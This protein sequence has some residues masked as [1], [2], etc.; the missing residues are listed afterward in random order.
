M[1]KTICLILAC[2]LLSGCGQFPP[3]RYVNS[4]ETIA[5]ETTAPVET[6]VPKE[7]SSGAAVPEP[8]ESQPTREDTL[9][10]MVDSMTLEQQVAQMFLVRCPVSDAAAFVGEH[11]PGGLILFSENILRQTPE[12]L[13]TALQNYQSSALYPLLIAVD[14]EGGSVTRISSSSA[15]RDS[16]F[17]SPRKAYWQGG[18]ELLLEQEAEKAKLLISLGINVNLAPVCDVVTDSSAFMA[19]RSLQLD[20]KHTAPLIASMVSTMNQFGL[21]CSLKHFPGYGNCG[22]THTGMAV[23]DRS[24]ESFRE[25]D[26]LPFQAGIEAGAGSV[27]VCHNIVTSMDV[28]LPASL[29]PAVHEILR[30]ELNFDGVILSDDLTMDAIA[31]AYGPGEAAVLAVLAGNDMLIT[32]WSN[33]QYEAVLTAVDQGRITPEQIRQSVLRILRWKMDLGLI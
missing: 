5:S 18:E 14:E 27:M 32:T 12:T 13:R 23:D 26:F 20:A 1:K 7:T 8:T 10:S 2:L 9:Q 30:R 24:L 22:D 31:S 28:S 11:Q 17:L 16:K 19:D 4:T 6:T 25:S 15:F 29:S 21:G 33:E 3:E